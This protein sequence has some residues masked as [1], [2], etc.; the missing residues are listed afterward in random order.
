M[1]LTPPKT[2]TF[3][4]FTNTGSFGYSWNVNQYFVCYSQRILVPGSRF[5]PA[6]FECFSKRALIEI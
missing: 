4:I 6:G 3:W 1:K 5:Y 2:V